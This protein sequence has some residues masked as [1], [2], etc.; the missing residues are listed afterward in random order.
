VSPIAAPR[1]TV[2]LV[3]EAGSP[4]GA[5]A[6]LDAHAPPGHLHLAIS[7]FLYRSDGALLL[8]QRAA[9]KYHFPGVWANACCSHPLPGEPIGA[10][11]VARVREELGLSVELALA[12]AFTY[13]ATCAVSGRI[14][15][16]YDWVF[17]GACDREP[18]P[19]PDEV[20]ATAWVTV[21][22]ARARPP[23]PLAPW[24]LPALEVAE[25]ARRTQST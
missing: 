1:D 21:L 10:A 18:V 19:S 4:I 8:Q 23:G 17:I 22:D 24:F 3:D 16:E 12:G 11:A 6:K 14:E 2:V 25:R 5:M 7:V 9:S 20:A 15:H 13:R